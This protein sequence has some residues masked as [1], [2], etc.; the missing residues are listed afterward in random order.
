MD[1]T[2]HASVENWPRLE[3]CCREY[4]LSRGC[5][6]EQAIPV[7]TAI[8]EIFINIASYAYGPNGGEA[9]VSLHCPDAG[10]QKKIVTVRIEDVG[11]PFDPVAY[12]SAAGMAQNART[13]TPGGLG[14]YLVKNSMEGLSYRRAGGKNILTFRKTLCKKITG[15]A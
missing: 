12:D 3:G 1:I 9:T 15:E 13:L 5:T 4:L 14:I 7:L 11:T 2:L 10:A 8:E 6:L